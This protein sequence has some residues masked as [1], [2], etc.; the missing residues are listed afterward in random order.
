MSNLNSSRR[1]LYFEEFKVGLRVVSA[2][3]TITESDIV[4]FAGLSGDYNQIHT[5]SVYSQT[6]PFGQRVAHGLL[7][8]SIA[9]GLAVQTGVLEGTVL[10]FREINEWKFTKP[11]YIGDTVHVEIEVIDAKALRRIGG[12]AVVLELNVLNQSGETTMRGTWTVLIASQPNA[13]QASE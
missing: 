11:V 2:G 10:A 12:G 4:N 5:D 1:G 3:R 6:T 7:V 13:E 9:S 8:L